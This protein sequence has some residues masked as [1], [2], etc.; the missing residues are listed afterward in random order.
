MFKVFR[1]PV[2]HRMKMSI[3][4][5]CGVWGKGVQLNKF[6]KS[7]EVCTYIGAAAVVVIVAT[8]KENGDD[9]SAVNRQKVGWLFQNQPYLQVISISALSRFI[10]VCICELC[11]FLLSPI[12]LY[13]TVLIVRRIAW[14]SVNKDP[15]YFTFTFYFIFHSFCLFFLISFLFFSIN[16]KLLW[17]LSNVVAT[18]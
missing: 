14:F 17:R 4:W 9:E 1:V 7:G 6:I 2:F 16:W 8:K 3:Q 5:C 18:A 10:F 12:Y 11:C 13:R 15:I